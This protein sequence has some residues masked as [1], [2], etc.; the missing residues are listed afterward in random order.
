METRSSSPARRASRPDAR[1]VSANRFSN[2]LINNDLLGNLLWTFA[3]RTLQLTTLRGDEPHLPAQ[4]DQLN[5]SARDITPLT[6]SCAAR[7]SRLAGRRRAGHPRLLRPA[8]GVAGRAAVPHRRAAL[9]RL[10]HLRRRRALADVPQGERQLRALRGAVLPRTGAT[11][12]SASSGCAARSATPGTSRR[13]PAAYARS[14]AGTAPPININ[15]AGA[16]AAGAAGNPNLRPSGSAR[17]SW[18]STSIL[19]DRAASR[20]PTTTSARATCCSRA[21]SRRAPASTAMLDNIG[22]LSNRGVELQLNTRQRRTRTRFRWGSTLIYSR[23]RNIAWRSWRGIRSS[24][25]TA[26]GSR[27]ASR[28]ACSSSPRTQRD[29]RGNILTTTRSGRCWHGTPD[30]RQPVAGL[31]RLA[32]QRVQPRRQLVG[33]RS[34]STASSA[35]RSGTRRA[36]SWTSSAPGRSTTSSLRG[37]ITQAQRARLQSIWE[38]YLEDASFVKLREHRAALQRPD[39]VA[40][41]DRRPGMQMELLGRNL[42]TWTGYTGYDPGDQH[43][44]PAARWSAAS[45]S[46]CTRTPARYSFGVRL[47]F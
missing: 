38:Y 29:D 3:R 4:S 36:G 47:N 21:C 20:S 6:R 44:R 27:R 13:S 39:A 26:T 37:E 11:A 45:T 22:E 9:G 7:C 10:V 40:R 5:A 8:A 24:P 42:H 15:R 43:V 1:A 33:F 32:S 17:W 25:A 2:R 12:G 23:N 31:D 35:T 19:A 34:C 41:G 28:W 46:P 30:R 16:R 18:G 14:R